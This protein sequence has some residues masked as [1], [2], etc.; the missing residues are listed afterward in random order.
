MKISLQNHRRHYSAIIVLFVM[1]KLNMFVKLVELP[2]KNQIVCIKLTYNAQNAIWLKVFSHLAC[3]VWFK[4]WCIFPA[5]VVCSG[6]CESCHSNP[7]VDQTTRPRLFEKGDLLPSGDLV[8]FTSGVKAKQSTT[9]FNVSKYEI[10]AWFEKLKYK[11][12]HLLVL[13]SRSDFIL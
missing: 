9:G 12:I 10:L 6:W 7:H 2:F 11:K 3:L 8:W 5:T 13:K 1:S 4:P